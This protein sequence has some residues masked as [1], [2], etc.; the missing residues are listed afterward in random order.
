MS[1]I[2][3][4][5]LPKLPKSLEEELKKFKS[6]DYVTHEGEPIWLN[7]ENTPVTCPNYPEDIKAAFEM[8]NQLW[9][10]RPDVYAATINHI[11]EFGGLFDLLRKEPKEAA[12]WICQTVIQQTKKMILEAKV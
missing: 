2:P 12:G 1:K 5:R 11:K 9:K 10:T 3:E 6:L 7:E 4:I 8:M